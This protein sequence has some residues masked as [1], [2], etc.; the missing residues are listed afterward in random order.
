MTEYITPADDLEQAISI[1]EMTADY[2]HQMIS[3]I[4]PYWAHDYRAAL[5]LLERIKGLP[6]NSLMNAHDKSCGCEL[7]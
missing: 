6:E 7:K 2:Y 5:D 1:I 4:S 3:E